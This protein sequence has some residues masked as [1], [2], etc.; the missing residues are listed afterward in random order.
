MN[1]AA[2]ASRSLIGSSR[3]CQPNYRDAQAVRVVHRIR[4]GGGRT[5]CTMT[6]LG[7]VKL[8]MRCA[9]E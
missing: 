1:G 9:N 4:R 3:R 2:R 8:R 7:Y 5:G 6:R